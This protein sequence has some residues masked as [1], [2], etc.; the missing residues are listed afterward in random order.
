[1]TSAAAGPPV[2]ALAVELRRLADEAA[3]HQAVDDLL[4]QFL[5][6]LARFVLLAVGGRAEQLVE[7][8]VGEDAA[9]EQCIEDGIVQRLHRTVVVRAERIAPGVAEPAREQQVRQLRDQIVEVDLVEQV[10][11]VLRVA[12]LHA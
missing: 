7:G 6:L 12:E 5:E 8:F 9:V 11:G 3:F 4:D 1:M 2:H 10:A